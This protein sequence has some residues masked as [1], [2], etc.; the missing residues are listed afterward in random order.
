MLSTESEVARE[1]FERQLPGRLSVIEAGDRDQ[2]GI[3]RKSPQ[4]VCVQRSVEEERQRDPGRTPGRRLAESHPVRLAMEYAE[5]QREQS[6]NGTDEGGIEPPV[7][8]ERKEQVHAPP[9]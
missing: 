3:L 8:A 5:V 9:L 1:E 4:P 7:L 2:P 6:E